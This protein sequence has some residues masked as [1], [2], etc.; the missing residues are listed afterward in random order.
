MYNNLN[1]HQ[2]QLYAVLFL[3]CKTI[4]LQNWLPRISHTAE[5]Y[6]TLNILPFRNLGIFNV[7]KFLFQL[8]EISYPQHLKKILYYQKISKTQI[9]ETDMIF[10]FLE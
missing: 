4:K 5:A 7:I 1:I 10:I 9:L 8:N 6:W 2:L 3:K